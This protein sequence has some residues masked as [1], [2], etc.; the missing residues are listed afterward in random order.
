[1]TT[2]PVPTTKSHLRKQ[3][4]DALRTH[5]PK[6]AENSERIWKRLLPLVAEVAVKPLA[7][8]YLDFGDEVETVRFLDD[9]R[10]VVPELAVPFVVGDS[11]RLFR[12]ESLD[13]FVRSPLGVLEPPQSLR[14]CVQSR[15]TLDDVGVAIIPGLAFDDLGN[16]LGRGRGFFDRFLAELSS[17]VPRIALAFECQ[18]VPCVP[19]TPHDERVEW[20]VTE[21]GV[22][23]TCY[24][25]EHNHQIGRVIPS[26]V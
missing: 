15:V 17:G 22:H 16:R 19:T 9:L 2:L 6:R 7:F 1:M 21:E 8:V 26:G 13:G 18:R 11:L 5:S 14:D 24:G 10:S 25:Y 20:I 23:A 4:R 3:M 12:F